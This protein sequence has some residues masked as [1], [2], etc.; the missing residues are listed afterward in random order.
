MYK[1]EFPGCNYSTEFRT[2][3]EYHHIIP[4]KN[5]GCNKPKNRVWLCPNHHKR[6]YIPTELNGIHSV[7][8]E[9]S[10]I[11]LGWVQ[12]TEGRILEWKHI[13]SEEIIF[14]TFHD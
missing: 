7:K 2:Q 10:I 6:V 1:C 9:N 13:D 3:I 14:G 8:N 11:I 4:K 5:G 12:S